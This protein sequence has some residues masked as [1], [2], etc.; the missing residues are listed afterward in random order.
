MA[1]F[2]KL[3]PTRGRSAFTLLQTSSTALPSEFGLCPAK[4]WFPKREGPHVDS[5]GSFWQDPLLDIVCKLT[6][7][8][9][10]RDPRRPHATYP[11]T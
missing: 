11:N 8:Y 2:K 3:P 7:T 5:H 6:S 10:Q 9:K 4:M 1:N